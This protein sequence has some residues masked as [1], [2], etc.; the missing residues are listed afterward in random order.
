MSFQ[1]YKE[2][3]NF[4]KSDLN[5]VIPTVHI[6]ALL[7]VFIKEESFPYIFWYRTA[8]FFRSRNNRICFF[9]SRL[10]LRHFSRKTGLHISHNVQIGKGLNI[11]H[12]GNTY[13]HSDVVIGENCTILHNVTIGA[14]FPGNPHVPVIG[15]GVYIGAN[16]VII[17]GIT[18]G[19]KVMIGANSVVTKS[20][21]D[22]VVIAGVP[23]RIISVNSRG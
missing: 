23:A 6:G 20:F 19:S 1:K 2:Y 16:A 14:S 11:V 4:I 18:I 9:V 22:N 3:F 13:V 15:D 10:V 21:P 17:G 12:V 7:C 8:R 5:R